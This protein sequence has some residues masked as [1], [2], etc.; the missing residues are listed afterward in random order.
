MVQQVQG[1][2]TRGG[3]RGWKERIKYRKQHITT[4]PASQTFN[5]RPY[6]SLLA[7]VLLA[8]GYW[9]CWLDYGCFG[10]DTGYWILDTDRLYLLAV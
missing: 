7:A 1:W 3:A 9:C 4:C 5:G 10:L 6:H 2:Y 8:A